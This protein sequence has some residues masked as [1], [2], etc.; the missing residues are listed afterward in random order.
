MYSHY[1]GVSWPHNIRVQRTRAR[2]F[3]FGW[4]VGSVGGRSP[5][6]RRPLGHKGR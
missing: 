2:G 4:L 6:T 3:V 1:D 5:L